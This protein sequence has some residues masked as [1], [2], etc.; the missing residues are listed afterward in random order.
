M[1]LTIDLPRNWEVK[2]IEVDT[3]TNR[4]TIKP[5]FL[6]GQTQSTVAHLST[7][8]DSGRSV[9]SLLTLNGN[10]GFPRVVRVVESDKQQGFDTPETPVPVPEPSQPAGKSRKPS[11]VLQEGDAE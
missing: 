5:L 9:K 8:G 4:I 2:S 1:D 11:S 6:K 10:D 3:K 7:T